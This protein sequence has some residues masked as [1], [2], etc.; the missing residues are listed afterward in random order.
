MLLAAGAWGLV[1]VPTFIQ[2][3]IQP[4][5]ARFS[6]C[7]L[8]APLFQ[9]NKMQAQLDG[10]AAAGQARNAS[11]MGALWN[12]KLHRKEKQLARWNNELVCCFVF[13]RC[14]VKCDLWREEN[15]ENYRDFFIL[16]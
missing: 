14:A 16:V 5:E 8:Y 6:L 12:K 2:E 11:L 13:L 3:R 4:S 15:T 10:G 7:L 9:K 1:G